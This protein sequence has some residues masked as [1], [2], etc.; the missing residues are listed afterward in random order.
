MVKA[1]Y[2]VKL[3]PDIFLV[4]HVQDSEERECALFVVSQ[5]VAV[6]PARLASTPH[7]LDLLSRYLH[8]R[9]RT[10][11]QALLHTA[12][13]V[14]L[15][16]DFSTLR[17]APAPA[18]P[19][20][21]LAE[22][23]ADLFDSRQL[24]DEHILAMYEILQ[25][26][27][28]AEAVQSIQALRYSLG[29][30][31]GEV[32]Q[33]LP[34]PDRETEEEA[35]E[36]S[37]PIDSSLLAEVLADDPRSPGEHSPEP[38]A[39]PAPSPPATAGEAVEGVSTLSPQRTIFSFRPQPAAPAHLPELPA[40]PPSPQPQRS[41]LPAPPA[42]PAQKSQTSLAVDPAAP[43]PE[44]VRP[45]QPAQ[46]SPLKAVAAQ[47][48]GAAGRGPSDQ[49]TA[50]LYSNLLA[51]QESEDVAQ[52]VRRAYAAIRDRFLDE[53]L[54]GNLVATQTLGDSQALDLPPPPASSEPLPVPAQQ[55]VEADPLAELLTAS[56]RLD[57]EDG[58]AAFLQLVAKHADLLAQPARSPAPALVPSQP[59]QPATAL[60]LAVE[61]SEEEPMNG[62]DSLAPTAR[63]NSVPTTAQ[64][65]PANPAEAAHVSPAPN[66]SPAPAREQ[67]EAEV[68]EMRRSFFELP[69]LSPRLQSPKG[70]AYLEAGRTSLQEPEPAALLP[71]PSVGAGRRVRQQVVLDQ[72]RAAQSAVE[73]DYLQHRIERNQRRV[74]IGQTALQLLRQQRLFP[75]PLPSPMAPL[76]SQP[77]T[78]PPSLEG[79][80]C[81]PR[82]SEHPRPTVSPKNGRISEFQ[83]Q[84]RRSQGEAFFFADP[85]DGQRIASFDEVDVLA[86]PRSVGTAPKRSPGGPSELSQPSGPPVSGGLVWDI[87]TG[88][89]RPKSRIKA[90]VLQRPTK[91]DSDLPALKDKA[92]SPVK[93]P[94]AVPT[95]PPQYSP[96][97]L[98]QPAAQAPE[99][100]AEEPRKERAASANRAARPTSRSA[101]RPVTKTLS[102]F[103]QVSPALLRQ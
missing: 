56:Q 96:R 16:R 27:K 26:S 51:S 60:A 64:P 12:S 92:P 32:A 46:E 43:S 100:A 70:A 6:F 8:Y 52:Y 34:R 59:S 74:R 15:V 17:P 40:A 37:Q 3:Q 31:V 29:E 54:A 38:L 19:A 47:L 101:V 25:Q 9:R 4:F 83:P 94:I 14:C 69:L 23:E 7:L 22:E 36:Q 21:L 73:C 88:E 99:E 66:P 89:G 76:V 48:A 30:L 5:D 61:T 98:P 39:L 67:R 55:Q 85:A 93:E 82:S 57:D 81:P 68:A 1:F 75:M 72:L 86:A 53:A 28:K 42:L 84:S 11:D 63:E 91:R 45:P 87:D 50:S 18:H 80:R 24:Y 49:L 71:P 79:D 77:A 58:R 13:L 95:K 62:P 44:E 97:K 35:A 78:R 2:L 33:G 20:D 102:N 10:Q 103:T 41:P 90:A 65:S